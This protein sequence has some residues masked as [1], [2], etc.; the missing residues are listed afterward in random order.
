MPRCATPETRRSAKAGA[1]TGSSRSMATRVGQ[2]APP[3]IG[4]TAGVVTRPRPAAAKSRAMPATPIA[5]GRFG[6]R[7]ISMTGSSS[8]AY[9]A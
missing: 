9:V 6:V 2:G 8:P 7:L 5:S 4:A 1:S 3:S